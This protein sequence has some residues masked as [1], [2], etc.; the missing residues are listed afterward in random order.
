MKTIALILVLSIQLSHA[1][2]AMTPDEAI[3]AAIH[4]AKS[5]V[6]QR[7]RDSGSV[8]YRNVGV[9]RPNASNPYPQVVCGEVNA[10]NG[11]GGYTGYEIFVWSPVPDLNGTVFIGPN[12][13]KKVRAFCHDG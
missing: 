8:R 1:A 5:A 13:V 2:L 9:Y 10:R 11:F 7:L 4:N 12:E 3:G 6:E